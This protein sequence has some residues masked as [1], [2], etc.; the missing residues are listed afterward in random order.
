MGRLGVKIGDTVELDKERWC[1]VLSDVSILLFDYEF[2][3]EPA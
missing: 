1:P 3:Q 2:S